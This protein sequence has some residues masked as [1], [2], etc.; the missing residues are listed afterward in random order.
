MSI[1]KRA[2]EFRGEQRKQV[3]KFLSMIFQIQKD[4]YDDRQRQSIKIAKQLI[5]HPNSVLT[6]KYSHSHEKVGIEFSF[7][8]THDS[9]MNNL[10][11]KSL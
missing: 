4:H 9:P 1:A 10:H 8:I 11:I 6:T 2:L 3:Q 5:A 7:C